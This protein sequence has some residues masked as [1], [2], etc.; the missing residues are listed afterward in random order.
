[1]GGASLSSR[2]NGVGA[3]SS[4]GL[5]GSRCMNRLGAVYQPDLSASSMTHGGSV[6]GAPS[7][8]PVVSWASKGKVVSEVEL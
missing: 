3:A 4:V 1:M 8:V 6:W 5:A 2:L 7:V